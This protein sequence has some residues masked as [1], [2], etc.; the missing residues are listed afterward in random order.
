MVTNVGTFNATFTDND[1]ASLAANRIATETGGDIVVAPN[2][3]VTFLYDGVVSL[4]R[5]HR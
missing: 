4:W 1:A 3:T 2:E 5:L